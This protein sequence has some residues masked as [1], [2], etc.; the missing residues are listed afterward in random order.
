VKHL[1]ILGYH[2]IGPPSPEGWDTWYYVPEA[3][4]RRHLCAAMDQGWEI[5]DVD[6]MLAGLDDPGS[7]PE[8]SA[9]IT[10]DDA[11]RCVLEV[12]APVLC[13]LGA[14]AVIFVPTRYIGGWNDFD[15]GA[16]PPEAICSWSDLRALEA[17]GVSVQSHGA[18]H[19]AM[20]GLDRAGQ[21]S[22]LKVSKE[23]LEDGLAKS[24]SVFAFP[25]G[26][27]GPGGPA[28]AELLAEAGYRAAC[29]YDDRINAVAV[30]DRFALS[31]LTIG[32]DT[33]VG[34]RLAEVAGP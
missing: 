22:E 29:L 28:M 1:A 25:F 17:S 34:G 14:P 19:V 16:E 9:V 18:A 6:T 31:R 21:T 27:G 32:P 7:L 2:K 3:L 4:F 33:D 24:V 13:E 10:F 12:A 26:D 30:P 5:I 8:H 15:E 11:Y 20:S 23:I